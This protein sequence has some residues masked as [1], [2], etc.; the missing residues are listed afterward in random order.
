M[1]D[2]DASKYE[3]KEKVFS[4]GV[5]TIGQFN[6]A[7]LPHGIVRQINNDNAIYEGQMREGKLYGYGR[8][9]FSSGSIYMGKYQNNKRHG[10]GTCINANGVVENGRWLENE[11]V[12]F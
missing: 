4:N 9:F 11:F 12:G 10:Q 6:K 1:I 5:K 7:G 2:I 3:F 8:L